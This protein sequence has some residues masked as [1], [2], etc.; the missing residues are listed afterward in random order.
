MHTLRRVWK[1]IRAG[2]NIDIYVTVIVAI[3]L[4]VLN[5]LGID[6][7]PWM[8]SI[9]LAVLGL[10]AIALLGTRHHLDEQLERLATISSTGLRGRSALPPFRENGRTASEI[11]VGGTSLISAIIPHLEFFEQKLQQGGHIRFLL[12]DPKVTAMDTWNRLSPVPHIE[13]DI[14]RVLNALAVLI[15]QD[16][17]ANGRCEVRLAPVFLPFGI[18]AFDPNKATG[19]MNVEIIAYKRHPGNRPH[20]LLTRQH[21]QHWFEFFCDQYEQLWSEAIPWQPTDKTATHS[22]IQAP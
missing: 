12:L 22:Q 11:F 18:T 4:V 21:D 17:N 15:Q 16:T 13:H 9:T 5:L 14:E 10:L 20:V 6:V 2:E 7:S 19:L 8:A 1:D 3:A